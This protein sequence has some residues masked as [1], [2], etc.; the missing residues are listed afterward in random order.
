MQQ[1]KELL[2][3]ARVDIQAFSTQVPPSKNWYSS[4][5]NMSNYIKLV[6]SFM[7]EGLANGS[8]HAGVVFAELVK[9]SLEGEPVT[10]NG[11][12]VNVFDQSLIE[13]ET[14]EYFDALEVNLENSF[15]ASETIV[16]AQC[17]RFIER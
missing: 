10:L 9:Q 17:G 4:A 16:K 8:R 11:S 15:F 6:I 7:L 13:E 14:L 5:M 1:L 3:K 12:F 2:K